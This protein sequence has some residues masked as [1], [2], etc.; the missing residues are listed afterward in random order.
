MNERY[1]AAWS[2]Q[3]LISEQQSDR[4]YNLDTRIA[5]QYSSTPDSREYGLSSSQS[6]KHSYLPSFVD[7]DTASVPSGA[8][9]HMLLF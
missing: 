2:H 9:E 4:M 1:K 8:A 5:N 6:V 3:R 7:Q